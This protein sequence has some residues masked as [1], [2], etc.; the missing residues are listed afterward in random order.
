MATA[1]AYFNTIRRVYHV[2]CGQSYVLYIWIR[3]RMRTNTR[4]AGCRRVAVRT[5][6]H[7][8][9]WWSNVISDMVEFPSLCRYF[10]VQFDTIYMWPQVPSSLWVTLGRCCRVSGDHPRPYPMVGQ[11]WSGIHVLTQTVP[12]PCSRHTRDLGTSTYSGAHIIMRLFFSLH[13]SESASQAGCAAML[14]PGC[15][16]V[17][18]WV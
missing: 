16:Y 3:W 18:E 5:R 10:L 1:L 7:G 2:D 8:C 6:T 9:P 17:E 12:I 13:S 4:R 14:A 15:C 11:S